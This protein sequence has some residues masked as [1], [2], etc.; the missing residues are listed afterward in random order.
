MR[1]AAGLS[2]GSSISFVSSGAVTTGASPTVT[3]P[4]GVQ[5]GDLLVLCVCSGGATTTPTGWV[6]VGVSGSGSVRIAT[7]YKIASG[8]ESNFT[9]G[10]TSNRTQCGVVCY[11]ATGGNGIYFLGSASNSGNSTTAST[12]S[13]SVNAVPALVVSH[14][15]KAPSLTQIGSV[16]GTT[17]RLAGTAD[18]NLTNLYVGD[19]FL[20]AT[21][22]TTARTE[23]ASANLNWETSAL[24]FS[25]GVAPT[26]V[27]TSSTQN[28][29]AG[30]SLVISKPTGVLDG[31]LL[32]AINISGGA[33]NGTWT[34]DTGWTE[35]ADQGTPA[36]LRVAYKIASSEGSSY[37]FTHTQSVLLGGSIIAYRGCSYDTIGTIVGG[38]TASSVSAS[39]N[40]SRLAVVLA[41]NEQNITITPDAKLV[42]LVSD[43]NNQSPS[44]NILDCIVQSGATGTKGGSASYTNNASAVIVSIKPA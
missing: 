35:I 36:N 39:S 42:S 17:S 40:F 20:S 24:Y 22:T 18:G 34:G 33:A 26:V 9:L 4:S 16:S 3:I 15:C 21:G 1:A 8:S 6:L 41:I 38:L 37:T 44:W 27:G 31:D 25:V 7:Y 29:G 14:F 43:N 11:R 2:S 12:I 28:S 19:E 10:N 32:L 23:S 13:Q 5:V 30:T